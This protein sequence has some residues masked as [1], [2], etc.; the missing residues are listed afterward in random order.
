MPRRISALLSVCVCYYL[1]LMPNYYF[2]LSGRRW[3]IHSAQ[4]LSPFHNSHH[5][6]KNFFYLFFFSTFA[7]LISSASHLRPAKRISPHDDVISFI[8]IYFFFISLSILENISHIAIHIAAYRSSSSFLALFL[9]GFKILCVP[10]VL[11]VACR[12]HCHRVHGIH[13]W[14]RSVKRHIVR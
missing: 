9:I 11:C 5:L 3:S 6:F 1:F 14:F 2:N 7:F 10:H 4:I 12:R 8:I 13:S